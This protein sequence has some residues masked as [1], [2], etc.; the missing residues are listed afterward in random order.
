MNMTFD[1]LLK[2]IQIIL[3]LLMIF[4]YQHLFYFVFFFFA[5]LP[6]FSSYIVSEIQ[7]VELLFF[8]MP[9]PVSIYNKFL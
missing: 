8:V 9:Y 3:F 1:W 4:L 5:Q 2:M 6:D 7:C